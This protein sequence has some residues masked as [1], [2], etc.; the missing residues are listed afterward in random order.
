MTRVPTGSDLQGPARTLKWDAWDRLVDVRKKSDNSLIAKFSYDGLTRRTTLT[1]SANVVNHFYYNADWRAVEERIDASA[2][3]SNVHY[4]GAQ[5]RWELIRRDR[6][7]NGNGTLDETLYCLRDA[8]DPLAIVDVSGAVQERF[9]YTTFGEVAFL[10]ADYS[11]RNASD[12]DWEFLFHGEFRDKETGYYN[13]GFRYYL[14]E[15]GRW[16]SRDPIEENGGVNLFGF[17]SNSPNSSF[18]ILGL[19]DKRQVEVVLTL[20]QYTEADA[21]AADRV[22]SQLARGLEK[23]KKNNPEKVYVELDGTSIKEAIKDVECECIKKLDIQS[24]G[25][26]PWPPSGLLIGAQLHQRM[27]TQS[28]H[29]PNTRKNRANIDKYTFGIDYIHG[30]KGPEKVSFHG[31]DTFPSKEDKIFCDS[32]EI[33]LRGCF[34]GYGTGGEMLR[35]KLSEITGCSV[36]SVTKLCYPDLT[37]QRLM[38]EGFLSD[39]TYVMTLF[40][41]F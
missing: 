40:Y 13:Y 34:I 26:I 29:N 20:K 10:A 31:L 41:R 30:K 18:D 28:H 25:A 37:G 3:P 27:F 16:M 5:N 6:D 35:S 12:F 33:V 22:E 17:V 4:W 39:P 36:R 32:C 8:M 14:P 11:V 9:Q 24:H 23:Y 2:N 19:Q 15:L 7:T 21:V 1:D 38:G